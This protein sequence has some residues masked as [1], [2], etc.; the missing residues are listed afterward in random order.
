[1]QKESG[2][3][4]IVHLGEL[5]SEN[6]QEWQHID[7][8]LPKTEALLTLIHCESSFGDALHYRRFV[9]VSTAD[10]KAGTFR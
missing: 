6:A 2:W 8:A 10:A 5:T 1:L 9:R 3:H 4:G 7:N